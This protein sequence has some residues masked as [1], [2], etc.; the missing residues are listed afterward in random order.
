MIYSWTP[1]T[2]S[3]RLREAQRH[4]LVFRLPVVDPLFPLYGGLLIKTQKPQIVM[5]VFLETHCTLLLF[6]GDRCFKTLFQSTS[7]S[8]MQRWKTPIVEEHFAGG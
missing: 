4:A 5:T 1:V 6:C 2:T 3:S 7:S 8:R